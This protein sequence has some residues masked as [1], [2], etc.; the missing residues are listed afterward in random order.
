M[1]LVAMAAL[2]GIGSLWLPLAVGVGVGWYICLP[3]FSW[4]KVLAHGAREEAFDDC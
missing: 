2:F 4:K 1:V 3:V